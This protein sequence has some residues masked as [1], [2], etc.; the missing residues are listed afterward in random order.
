[1][2]ALC[3]CRLGESLP[4][5]YMVSAIGV[6]GKIAEHLL[7]GPA[8]GRLATTTI[9]STQGLQVRLERR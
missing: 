7:G 2:L 5:G 8:N 1:M 6:A 3:T 9:A 4:E